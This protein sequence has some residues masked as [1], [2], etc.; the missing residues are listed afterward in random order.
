MATRDGLS[1]VLILTEDDKA[2]LKLANQLAIGGGWQEWQ[3]LWRDREFNYEMFNEYIWRHAFAK[4]LWGSQPIS[5]V[6]QECF[7]QVS[8]ADPSKAIVWAESYKW[9]LQQ[10]VLAPDP[11]KYLHDNLPKYT[12]NSKGMLRPVR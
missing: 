12:T 8:G 6:C 7:R 3:V 4:A 11:I 5:N 1:G 2:T 10:M 9:H